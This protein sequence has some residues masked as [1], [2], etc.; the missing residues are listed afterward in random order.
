M[1]R[2]KEHEEIGFGLLI[3]TLLGGCV[4]LIAIIAQA[5]LIPFFKPIID[6]ILGGI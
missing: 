5:Y 3:V 6:F 4:L 2:N 1:K